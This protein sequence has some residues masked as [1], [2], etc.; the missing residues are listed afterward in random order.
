MC[1]RTQTTL[2][3]AVRFPSISLPTV[4]KS[5]FQTLF[6]KYNH[7]EITLDEY[8]DLTGRLAEVCK[9]NDE[10]H[11]AVAKLI[12]YIDTLPH[13]VAREMWGQGETE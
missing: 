5:E 8:K 11:A 9:L 4:N 12:D 10:A 6:E 13:H 7:D 3:P 2:T 1:Y